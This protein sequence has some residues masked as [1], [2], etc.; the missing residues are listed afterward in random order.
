MTSFSVVLS[1]KA[2]SELNKLSPEIQI[3]IIADLVNSQR[4]I[5][6]TKIGHRKNIYKNLS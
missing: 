4:R 2:K 5:E 3:R 6:V 1:L